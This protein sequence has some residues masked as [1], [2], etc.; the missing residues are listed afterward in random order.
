MSNPLFL[1]NNNASSLLASAITSSSQTTISVTA[2]TGSLFPSPSYPTSQA[3]VTVEDVGGDIEVMYVTARTG[4]SLIVLRGQE[5]TTALSSVASGSRVEQRITQ[6]VLASF[7][8]KSN[9]DTIGSGTTNLTGPLVLG[10]GGSIQGG[11][12][13]GAFRSAPGV[14]TGQIL[15]S[16]ANAT[17]NGSNILTVANLLSNV[18]TGYDFCHT[19]MIVAWYGTTSN[20]PIG[21]HLCDGT[22]GTPN[23][24][25]Q[26]IVGST[27]STSSGSYSNTTGSTTATGTLN[28]YQLALN[29]LPAH[30]HNIYYASP[31]GNLISY[32]SGSVST[33]FYVSNGNGSAAVNTTHTDNN[34]GAGTNQHTHTFTG[35]AHTHSISGP[36]YTALLY[37]MKL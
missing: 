32:S 10:S 34:T 31:N 27:T 7:L 12:F 20:V 4:D 14:T 35:V 2:T 5:G 16:G 23:L 15:I 24:N 9:G 22:N 18:P 17:Q 25:N 13:T 33:G 11:E 26:F 37:I 6:G 21:W 19:N 1:F 30:V 36:P 3:A 28:G 29:D 8:Q